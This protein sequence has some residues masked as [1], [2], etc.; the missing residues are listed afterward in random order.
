MKFLSRGLCFALGAA[1]SC[2]AT[3]A[4]TLEDVTKRG[5]LNCGVS[6]GLYGFSERK[7][8]GNWSGFDVDFCKALAAAIFGDAG[9]VAYT[10]LSAAQRFDALKQARIDVL[11]RNS[12]WTLQREAGLGLAFAGINFK[13]VCVQ[14]GTSSEGVARDFFAENAMT[15]E[16]KTYPTAPEALQAFATRQCEAL[17]T[18]NSGLF[19]ERL[20]LQKPTDAVILPD[21]ISKEPLGPVIRADDARWHMIVKW[22]NFALINAEELGVTSAN[23]SQAGAS[24]RPDVRRFVGAEGGFGKMLGLSDDWAM[25][26]VAAVGNYG[27]IYER[28]VGVGSRLGIPRGLNQLWI[29]GGILFAPPM[30]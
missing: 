15:V 19:A 6:T 25:R 21:I 1:L 8:D 29:N 12:T 3:F 20:K 9:K 7:A 13:T 11:S 17:T 2:S 24:K 16:L 27:E 26:A 10:P 4:D 14:A 28:N 5:V 30:R 18:D 22:M 23:I